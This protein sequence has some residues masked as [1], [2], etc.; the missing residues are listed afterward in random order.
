MLDLPTVPPELLKDPDNPA[1]DQYYQQLRRLREVM[2]SMSARMPMRHIQ[3]VRLYHQGKSPS[4]IAEQLDVKTTTVSN[5]LN[6]EPAKRLLRT[7]QY[8]QALIDGPNLELRRNMLWRIAA[9]SEED[10][11]H[12]SIAS[13]KELNKLA[14]AYPVQAPQVATVTNITI[15]QKQLPRTKL[16][17]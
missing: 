5:A 4:A 1:N 3:Y 8:T 14:G 9:R 16:D 10:D 6:K 15:N 11:P 7:L 2:T 12:V 17:E 13:I